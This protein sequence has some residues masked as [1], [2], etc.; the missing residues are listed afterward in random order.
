M[1]SERFPADSFEIM[2]HD[3]SDSNAG[4]DMVSGDLR[5]EAGLRFTYNRQKA[6][7][8]MLCKK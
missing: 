8:M 3:L 7:R 2:I 4:R 1:K 5:F 6:C